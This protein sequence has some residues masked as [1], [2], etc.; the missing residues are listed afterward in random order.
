[1]PS[2]WPVSLPNFFS[3]PFLGLPL[4]LIA[5]QQ[6]SKYS[7]EWRLKHKYCVHAEAV[8]ARAGDDVVGNFT[9]CSSDT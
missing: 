4:C 1:M 9:A 8:M 5:E 3:L 7:I 2:S 6:I